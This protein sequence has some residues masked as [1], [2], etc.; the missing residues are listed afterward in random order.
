MKYAIAVFTLVACILAGYSEGI[1][2]D[3]STIKVHSQAGNEKLVGESQL[4]KNRD[5]IQQLQTERSR[6]I[7][8]ILTFGVLAFVI[9]SI[10]F[11]L[12]MKRRIKINRQLDMMQDELRNTQEQLIRQEKLA[13]LGQLTAGIAHEIKNPLNFI[14]NFSEVSMEL[15]NE[16]KEAKTEE[17]KSKLLS[18]LVMNMQRI[19]HH[20]KRA[21]HIVKNMLD[22]SRSGS[23][24]KRMTKVNQLCDEYYELAYHGFRATFPDFYCELKKELVQGMPD[25]N[26]VSQ[27]IARVLL[28]LFSNAFYAVK[29]KKD[30]RAARDENYKPEVSY[31]THYIKTGYSSVLRIR[32]RDNGTGIPDGV[33]EKI[34]DPFFTTKPAGQGTGL[35]LSLSYDMIKAHGGEMK[36][37]TAENKFTEFT[38]TLPC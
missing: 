6:L 5:N 17:E 29:E 13:S 12:L 26:L 34:F 32:I 30:K 15:L 9:V 2:S 24:E 37:E 22:H 36:V 8:Y 23:G 31:S 35:G 1:S 27:N 33:R 4:L 38:I 25:I 21:D 19:N 11:Y 16:M 20:G 10:V 7:N 14:N 28:S 18:D 3:I